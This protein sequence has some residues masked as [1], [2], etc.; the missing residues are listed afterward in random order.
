MTGQ[1][2]APERR[3]RPTPVSRR[4][5]GR[6]IKAALALVGLG[7]GACVGLAID[8]ETAGALRAPGGVAT[9]AGQLAGLTGA[10]LM[11]VMLLLVARIPVIEAAAG[12]DR[13]V[14]WHRN[15]GQ[16]PVCL[17]CLHVLL[18]TVGYAQSDH[19]GVIDQFDQFIESYPDVLAATVSL[20]LI[21]TA[22][23]LSIRSARRRM[24]YETW[25][26]I[27]LYL[28]LALALAFSH[29]LA[30]GVS[31]VGHPL[32]RAVWAT[33]WAA[34]AGTV[35]IFRFLMPLARTV[36]HGL[37]V[38]GIQRESEGVTSIVCSGRHLDRLGVE[39]GQFFHWRFLTRGMWWQAHPYSLSAL[40]RSQLVRFTVKELGDHSS[41]LANIP[42]GTRIAIEGPYGAFTRHARRRRRG[43][44]HR[45][46]CGR[47]P[48]S[49]PAR[50]PRTASRRHRDPAVFDR[51][52]PAVPGRIPVTG[53]QA[54]GTAGRAGRF[55]PGPS[56]GC[57]PARRSGAGHHGLRS[58]C[59]RTG[60]AQPSGDRRRPAT[61]TLG[62]PGS[63]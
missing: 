19:I 26:T 59:M 7:M 37:R 46:G 10:Y 53:R 62:G 54:P 12:Q 15:L 60:P 21:L 22:S 20:G 24:H 27:H 48:D 61:R 3:V 52:R 8:T 18:I 13:L 16:W 40:P 23:V 32:T 47:H 11:L 44:A 2:Q 49:G 38:V 57:S 50:A 33:A 34:T 58:V 45:S 56:A 29:Q 51:R 5:R 17:I 63:L 14:R 1:I 55:P 36:Y 43:P 30:N 25:W 39:G 6:I 42:L 4:H 28:Y 41:R 31:F 9:F 35:V